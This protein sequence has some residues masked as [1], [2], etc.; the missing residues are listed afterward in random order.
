MELRVVSIGD[1]KYATG[2]SNVDHE[3]Y[4]TIEFAGC[5]SSSTGTNALLTGTVRMAEDGTV[6]W[7]WVGVILPVRQ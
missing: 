6:R 4:P 2:L 7:S 5:S 3:T 1:P